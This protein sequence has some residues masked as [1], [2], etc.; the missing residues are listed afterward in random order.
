MSSKSK[1]DDVTRQVEGLTHQLS[2]KRDTVIKYVDDGFSLTTNVGERFYRWSDIETIT[3]YKADLMTYDDLRLDVDFGDVVLT[4]SEDLAGWS[5][6]VEMLPK[7]FPGALVDWESKVIQ[8][9]FATNLTL[10]Y[11]REISKVNGG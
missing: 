6:F 3:A 1:A 10:I 8:T 4:L 7:M 11:T 5:G 9:P 2:N